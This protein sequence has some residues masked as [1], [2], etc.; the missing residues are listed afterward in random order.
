MEKIPNFLII[1]GGRSGTTSLFHYLSE[2]PEI[3]MSPNKE[4]YFLTG[5]DFNK[6][7]NTPSFFIE[8]LWVKNFKSYNKDK[9]YE[10]YFMDH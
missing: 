3:Y 4:P 7:V 1:S 5:L 8:N 10:Y 9:Y 2:H 6:C